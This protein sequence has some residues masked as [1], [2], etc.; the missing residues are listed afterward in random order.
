MLINKNNKDGKNKKNILFTVQFAILLSIEALFCFVPI[1]GSIP[2]NP[3]IVATTAMLPVI[4]TALLLG[5]PAGTL[6]GFF[7]GLFSLIVWTFTPPNPLIAFLFTPFYSLGAIQGNGFSLIICIVPRVL[8]G[9]FSGLL[10]KA[11]NGVMGK[12]KAAETIMY[13]ICGIAGSL[14]NTV[15]VLAGWYLFFAEEIAKA[16]EWELSAVFNGAIIFTFLTNGIPELIVSAVVAVFVC[17]P[18][19]Y[20]LK[21]Q[22]LI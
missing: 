21:K 11:L 15:F 14:A 13:A 5:T 10:F 2:F 18:L 1:L 9:L 8:I 17:M 20:V 4:I 6:M 22:N 3:V 19:R 16:F 7:A 12:N